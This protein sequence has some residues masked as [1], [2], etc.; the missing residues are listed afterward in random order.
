VK[1]ARDEAGESLS[2]GFVHYKSVEDAQAAIAVEN[3]SEWDGKMIRVSVARPKK[4]TRYCKII[5]SKIAPSVT[6]EE[7]KNMFSQV[8][9]FQFCTFIDS[10]SSEEL[11][12]SDS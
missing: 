2:Y 5:I 4:D 12:K 8:L 3:S 7:L 11:S 1:V 6:Q 10:N 9:F